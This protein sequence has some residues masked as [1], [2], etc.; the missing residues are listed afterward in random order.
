MGIVT[1]AVHLVLDIVIGGRF[2][3][4]IIA[5]M[6]AVV[7]YAIGVLRF[8]VLSEEDIK[9]FPKGDQIYRICKKLHLFKKEA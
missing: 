8:G 3:P 7:V 6:A 4:T 2:I 9:G 1:Y 5:I